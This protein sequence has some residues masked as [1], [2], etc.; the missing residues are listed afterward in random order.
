[1]IIN[2]NPP[3]YNFNCLKIKIGTEI[4]LFTKENFKTKTL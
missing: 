3:N 1:M 4:I 2:Y